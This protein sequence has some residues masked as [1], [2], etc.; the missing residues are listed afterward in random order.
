MHAETVTV[1]PAGTIV[2]TSTG[3]TAITIDDSTIVRNSET[4][5]L[6][7]T[8]LI[9]MSRDDAASPNG[10]WLWN[11]ADLHLFVAA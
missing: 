3:R 8:N 9:R 6:T 10:E 4:G 1:I 11:T 5:T 2:Q 7:A